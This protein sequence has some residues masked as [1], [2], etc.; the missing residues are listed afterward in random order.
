MQKH[1]TE[2]GVIYFKFPGLS[3]FEHL[4]THGMF[5][6]LGGVSQVPF[7]SLNT[8]F[9]HEQGA[10]HNVSENWGRISKALPGI[11][12]IT[13]IPEHR[14]KIIQVTADMLTDEIL[15]Y[16]PAQAD[17]LI[18]NLPG[19][20]LVWNTADCS[21]VIAIDP[22]HAAIGNFHAGWRG[23]SLC[24]VLSGITT[25]TSVFG[26]RPKDLWVGIGPTICQRCYQ[27]DNPI[28]KAF[29]EN[30]KSCGLSHISY[31]NEQG[32]HLDI[33]KANRDQLLSIGVLEEHIEVSGLCPGHQTD[34]FFS[35]RMEKPKTGRNASIIALL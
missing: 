15:T 32:L 4:I 34:L 1:T 28:L 17:G 22:I 33:A 16:I 13:A 19:I 26:S 21:G 23:C 9:K 24:A 3:K 35:H 31:S 25:M 10:E 14:D 2:D 6:R 8:S 20:G 27:V 7:N 18:T 12:F 11:R 5:S 30:P 29:E